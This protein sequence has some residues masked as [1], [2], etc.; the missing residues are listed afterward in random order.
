MGV[1]SNV[2]PGLTHQA[3]PEDMRDEFFGLLQQSVSSLNSML[4]EVMD[5][6]RLQA[7]YE[8][9][10]VKSFDAALLRELF[11]NLQPQA[12]ERGQFL[13]SRR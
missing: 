3:V 8:L 13:N 10:N 12:V 11:E 7:G 4:D 1:V 2:T 6:A 5:L 9:R